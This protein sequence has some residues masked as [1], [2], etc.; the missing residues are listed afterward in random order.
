MWL[1]TVMLL[2]HAIF[3]ERNEALPRPVAHTWPEPAV[4]RGKQLI[5]KLAD[6]LNI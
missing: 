2:E 6:Q 4:S 3:L 1:L 5:S